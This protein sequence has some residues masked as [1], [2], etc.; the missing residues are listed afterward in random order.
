[1]NY[2]SSLFRIYFMP[3]GIAR[4]F[5]MLFLLC[6]MCVLIPAAETTPIASY[7]ISVELIPDEKTVTGNE[8]V[9]WVNTSNEPVGE[10][11]FHLYLNA[12]KNELS[13]YFRERGGASSIF[14]DWGRIDVKAITLSDG[15]NLTSTIEYLHPDDDNHNDQTVMKLRLPKPVEAGASIQL[16]IE[17]TTKLP[18][19]LARSGF[20]GEYFFVGQWFPKLGVY[21]KPEGTRKGY[22]NCHQYHL[23]SEFFADFGNYTVAI[24]VPST[25]V[26]GATG[27]L[28]ETKV[29]ERRGTTTYTYS[30]AEVHDFAWSASPHFKR[31]ERT[32][33]PAREVTTKDVEAAASLLDLPVNDFALT[34]VKIILLLQPEHADQAERHWRS[35][36]DAI[37]LFGLRFGRYPY[38]TLT[39]IDTPV[40]AA[41]GGMEYPTLITSDTR[42]LATEE[43]KDLEA[44]IAHE[45]AHQYWYGMVASNEFEDALLDEG[46][47][48][49]SHGL[50]LDTIYAKR[51]FS[52]PFYISG[53]PATWF[54]GPLP[55]SNTE[56]S[57][58]IYLAAPKVDEGGKAAWHFFDDLSYSVNSAF[59]FSL[60]LKTLENNLGE[61]VMAKVIREYF[62]RWRFKHPKPADFI[63]TV[64][65]VSGKEFTGFFEQVVYGSNVLDYEVMEI[66]HRRLRLPRGQDD[67]D[68]IAAS[69]NDGEL[70]KSGYES[71]VVIRRIGE[72]IIPVEVKVTFDDGHV[73]SASWN[74]KGRW[75]RLKFVRSSGVREVEIDPDRKILLDVNLTNNS[76]S[77]ESDHSGVIKISSK[78]LFWLQ[79][80]LQSLAAVS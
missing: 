2:A 54:F 46:L 20:K 37:K 19:I 7:E 71:T 12:F 43:M 31:F 58:A 36:R 50:L 70:G 62:E 24:T 21:E 63:K 13:T 59:K 29:N 42:W 77:R 18:R 27:E 11:Q 38:K 25:Y 64:N 65:E 5:F 55:I 30:Q 51:Y 79:T 66:S 76:K 3:S 56:V 26:V 23:N 15:T 67:Q 52:L 28:K 16:Q 80:F 10:L 53:I 1:M 41:E 9:T 73:E 8:I 74:G 47:A 4:G 60:A 75:T 6:V 44:L 40:G 34:T 48:N 33:D 14:N 35:I 17:F 32:F 78:L 69:T 72:V 45:F 39:L 22:W 57:R 49:Y 61:K 68:R